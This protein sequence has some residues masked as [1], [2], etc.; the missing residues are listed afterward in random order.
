LDEQ[1]LTI[2]RA[3]LVYDEEIYLSSVGQV[4]GISS[5][6]IEVITSSGKLRLL[7]IEYNGVRTTEPNQIIKSIRKRLK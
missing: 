6:G 7:E 4:A 2:W 3:Q 1:K 5:T